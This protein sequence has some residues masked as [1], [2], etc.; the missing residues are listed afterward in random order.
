M[1]HTG[2]SK[3]AEN[4]QEL[5]PSGLQ[6]ADRRE[7]VYFYELIY[8]KHRILYAKQFLKPGRL[9]SS[10]SPE[11]A[12]KLGAKCGKHKNVKL[13]YKTLKKYLFITSNY[14]YSKVPVIN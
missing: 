2:N 6:A 1:T 7:R 12:L 5:L 9:Y 4:R 3:E 10:L 13:I 14:E 8:V 11:S